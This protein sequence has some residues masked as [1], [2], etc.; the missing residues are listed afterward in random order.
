MSLVF[1]N[2]IMTDFAIPETKTSIMATKKRVRSAQVNDDAIE[3]PKKR[4]RPSKV[5]APVEV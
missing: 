3:P 4:G 2:A 5:A 1:V